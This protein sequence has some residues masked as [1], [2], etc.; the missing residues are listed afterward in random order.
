MYQLVCPVKYRR[1][2]FTKEVEETL[3]D[4]C[5]GIA[6]RYEVNFIEIGADDDHVHFLIQ[7][8]PTYSPTKLASLIKGITAREIFLRHPTI[9]KNILWGGHFWT[10]GYYIN[11]VGK[12]ANENMMRNY[13]KNQGMPKTNYKPIYLNKNQLVLFD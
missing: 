3:K 2:V 7:S 13:I 1:A 9:K 11:T 12:F 5:I 10:A 6:E 8:I 4:V